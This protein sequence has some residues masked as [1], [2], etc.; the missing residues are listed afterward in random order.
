M[1]SL[2]QGNVKEFCFWSSES[3]SGLILRFIVSNKTLP[4]Q[5]LG[6]FS[7]SNFAIPDVP[8]RA[9]MV[10]SSPEETEAP[11]PPCC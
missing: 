9:K 1:V 10:G 7:S 11:I 6:W 8:H 3:F 4:S 2:T 5:A